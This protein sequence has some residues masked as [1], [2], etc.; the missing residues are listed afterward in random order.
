MNDALLGDINLRIIWQEKMSIFIN[1]NDR[2]RE[3]RDY[4]SDEDYALSCANS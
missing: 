1:D 3:R 2:T 4:N